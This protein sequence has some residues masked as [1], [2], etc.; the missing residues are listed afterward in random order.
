VPVRGV[1]RPGAALVAAG[2]LAGCGADTSG[3]S[4]AGSP[5]SAP[6]N[7][8]VLSAADS[9]RLV[10]WFRRFR[11]CV[12][13]YGIETDAI[14]VTRRELSMETRTHLPAATLAARTVPCGEALGD[15]PTDAS[16]QV[17]RGE[18]RIVLYLPKRCLLDPK[19]ARTET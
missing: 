6:G 19:V 12:E 13:R 7:E 17:R 10:A 18:D 8:K 14:V 15:P 4:R 16:L 1:A 11:A 2:L 9:A 3:S 5:A